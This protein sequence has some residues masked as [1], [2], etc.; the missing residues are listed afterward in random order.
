MKDWSHYAIEAGVLLYL[1][2]IPFS[3]VFSAPIQALP[4][5]VILVGKDSWGVFTSLH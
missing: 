3:D 2:L 1:L 5:A 4:L